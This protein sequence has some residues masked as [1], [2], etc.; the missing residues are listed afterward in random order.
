MTAL[1]SVR[2]ADQKSAT[3]QQKG[4]DAMSE[5]IVDQLRGL[6][7]L[8]RAK[9]DHD[10]TA[11]EIS[12]AICDLLHN[13][14]LADGGEDD[15]LNYWLDDLVESRCKHMDAHRWTHDQCGL[16]WHQFCHGCGT[17]RYPEVAGLSHSEGPGCTEEEYQARQ[18]PP[19][20]NS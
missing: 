16:W 11:A 17:P 8:T 14:N 19:P 13:L 9:R 2:F 18:N 15:L 5:N 20:Q 4:R 10:C 12:G 3:T 6:V 7:I 1:N